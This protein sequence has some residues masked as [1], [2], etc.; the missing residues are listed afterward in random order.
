RSSI[1]LGGKSPV[2]VFE[3][4]DPELCVDAALAQI[5]TMNGQ[6]CTA[7]SRLLVQEGLYEQIVAA[8]AARAQRIRV[9]DPTDPRTELGPLIRPEHHARVLDYIASAR[10][11]GARVLAGGERPAELPDGNYLKATVIADVDED[12]KVFQEEIFGPV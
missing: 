11:A 7:G 2:V 5:F 12:M 3:D 8:V 9:G 10:A 6:R 4:A 1:E